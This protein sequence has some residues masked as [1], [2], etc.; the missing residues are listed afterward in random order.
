MGQTNSNLYILT[1]YMQW[2]ILK[3]DKCSN[4]VREIFLC[5]CVCEWVT[6]TNTK[7]TKKDYL[8]KV[9]Y[10]CWLHISTVCFF[11]WFDEISVFETGKSLT[12]K[13]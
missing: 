1:Q 13:V 5:V 12:N 8:T 9:S 6:N 4:T 3:H 11:L 7:N 10:A 2:N